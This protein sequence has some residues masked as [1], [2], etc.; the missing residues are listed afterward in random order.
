M[1][2]LVSGAS[3]LIGTALVERLRQSPHSAE[4]PQILRLVRRPP[5]AADEVFWD[6]AAGQLDPAAL[7]GVEAAVH[8]AGENLAAGR[9]NAERKARIRESRVEGTRLLSRTLA[10]LSPLPRV[11]LSASA[12]GFYGDRGEEELHEG[13]APGSGFLA[14]VCRAWETATEPAAAAGIRV[15]TA[16]FGVVLAQQGGALAQMLTPFRWGLGG[17]MGSGRQYV[18]WITLDDAVRAILFLLEL[19]GVQGPVNVVAPEPV[20]NREMAKALGRAL[21]RPAILPL[22]AFVLRLLFG[23]LADEGLLASAR[24]YPRRLTAAGFEFHDPAIGETMGRL[25]REAK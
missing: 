21:H 14:E 10:Q 5:R 20:T 2:I 13:S 19:E 6:P 24:V 8:L 25:V 16:R 12:I 3:G 15:A 7:E 4:P 18:S 22:P 1:R 23:E 17:P 11:L 9:W